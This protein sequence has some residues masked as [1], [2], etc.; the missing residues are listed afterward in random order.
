MH[1]FYHKKGLT[2]SN[3]YQNVL[4]VYKSET[5]CVFSCHII[6]KSYTKFSTFNLNSGFA[7]VMKWWKQKY[8][9]RFIYIYWIKKGTYIGMYLYVTLELYI[10]NDGVQFFIGLEAEI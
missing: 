8:G 4:K 1:F 6:E 5:L 7:F 3:I 2:F 10:T 9:F